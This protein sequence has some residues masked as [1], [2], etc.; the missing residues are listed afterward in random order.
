MYYSIVTNMDAEIDNHTNDVDVNIYRELK[1]FVNYFK[2]IKTDNICCHQTL[3]LSKNE[4]W[5]SCG[6][7]SFSKDEFFGDVCLSVESESITYEDVE[8]IPRYLKS[9]TNITSAYLSYVLQSVD[10]VSLSKEERDI[11]ES[12]DRLYGLAVMK[13]ANKSRSDEL[14]DAVGY[15][16]EFV[17]KKSYLMM[18]L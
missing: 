8:R 11:F 13:Q 18:R 4:R 9:I 12:Y 7:R 1:Q 15:M 2:S 14:V 5:H 17:E 6:P 16:A 10:I 3:F